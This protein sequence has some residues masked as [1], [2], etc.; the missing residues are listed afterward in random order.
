MMMMTMATR[1][2][3][4]ADRSAAADCSHI[5]IHW[6]PAHGTVLHIWYWVVPLFLF[7]HAHF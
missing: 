7:I 1:R 2:I 3:P 6:S 5:F 4:A